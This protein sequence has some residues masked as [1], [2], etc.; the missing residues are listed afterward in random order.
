ML[1]SQSLWFSFVWLWGCAPAE[2]SSPPAAPVPLPPDLEFTASLSIDGGRSSSLSVS[3]PQ[4]RF[5]LE[6]G[7]LVFIGP[8]DQLDGTLACNNTDQTYFQFSEQT[9]A[10]LE[11]SRA[12]DA[13]QR[14]QSA[15]SH[16]GIR[17][18]S[19]SVKWPFQNPC[20]RAQQLL[21]EH[22]HCAAKTVGPARQV[23]IHRA[24]H[25]EGM[26]RAFQQVERTVEHEFD[27]SLGLLLRE[28]VSSSDRNT[29][30]TGPALQSVR[31]T[32]LE[33][34]TFAIPA[35]YR[36]VA[37]EQEMATETRREIGW[38]E[39]IPGRTFL[40]AKVYVVDDPP[41]P[42][43][44]RWSIVRERWIHTEGREIAA[45]IK[46]T[47]AVPHF[48]A[49]V[50]TLPVEVGH[51]FQI[52]QWDDITEVGQESWRRSRRAITFADRGILFHVDVFPEELAEIVLLPLCRGL[53]KKGA[54][55]AGP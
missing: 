22:T 3:L 17:G 23:W 41:A 10:E 28:S 6:Q 25:R 45:V 26:Q 33:P 49:D 35:G 55:P 32:K 7:N 4:N 16:S 44:P 29:V 21:N 8:L 19:Q 53:I 15:L 42:A 12:R 18:A 27:P 50:T 34:A 20:E 30:S 52:S 36:E 13:L 39:M 51:D 48:A 9:L 38:P 31:V 47:S 11:S 43:A 40:K 14:Y 2:T 24:T 5:R 46:I 54:S 1:R 37:T